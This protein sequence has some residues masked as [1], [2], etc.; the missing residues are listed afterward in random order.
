[1]TELDA[2]QDDEGRVQDDREQGE[3]NAGYVRDHH[4]HADDATVQDGVGDEELLHGEGCDRGAEGEE[5][6]VDD[7]VGGT[8]IHM[9]CLSVS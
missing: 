9:R 8:S 2:A 4:A 6:V 7:G 3:G 1:M 5:R